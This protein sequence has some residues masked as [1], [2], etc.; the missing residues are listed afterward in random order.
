MESQNKEC[1]KIKF[2]VTTRDAGGISFR[3]LEPKPVQFV[4]L[5]GL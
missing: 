3:L 2:L 5:Y 4:S 1:K